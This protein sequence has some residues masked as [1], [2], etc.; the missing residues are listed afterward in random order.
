VA[1]TRAKRMCALSVL[2]DAEWALLADIVARHDE[3]RID[4]GRVSVSL[5]Q[6]LRFPSSSSLH[7]SPRRTFRMKR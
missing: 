1:Q 7:P 6:S 3:L 4:F 2:F 5:S